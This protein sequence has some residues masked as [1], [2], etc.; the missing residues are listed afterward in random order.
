MYTTCLQR[1]HII[2]NPLQSFCYCFHFWLKPCFWMSSTFFFKNALSTLKT[3]TL[4]FIPGSCYST[5][6]VWF[7]GHWVAQLGHVWLKGRAQVHLSHGNEGG[8][9]AALWLYTLRFIR[10]VTY[11]LSTSNSSFIFSKDFIQNDQTTHKEQ[12]KTFSVASLSYV[13]A[14]DLQTVCMRENTSVELDWGWLTLDKHHTP[15]WASNSLTVNKPANT[16][17]EDKY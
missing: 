16:S 1:L 13:A 11:S 2:F 6:A 12:N 7:V 15:T 4:L 17:Y 9:S 8:A 3:V 10:S 5:I 14:Q